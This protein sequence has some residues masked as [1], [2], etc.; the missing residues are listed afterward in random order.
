MKTQLLER[1]CDKSR[2]K[3]T[4]HAYHGEDRVEYVS[5]FGGDNRWHN[6]PVPWIEYLP[7]TRE[8]QLTVRAIPGDTVEESA[9]ELYSDKFTRYFNSYGVNYGDLQWRRNLISFFAKN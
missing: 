7:I 6:V 3:V 9:R 2:I 1:D 4:A 5:V 8:R